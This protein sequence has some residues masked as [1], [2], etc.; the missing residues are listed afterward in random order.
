[1]G[2]HPVSDQ[3]GQP[4][5][6]LLGALGELAEQAGRD[7]VDVAVALDHWSPGDAETARQLGPQG[8]GVD[9]ADGALLALQEPGV[10]RQPL[11]GGVL[12]LGGHDGVGV[13]LGIG[14]AA[15]VLAEQRDGQASGVDLLDAVLPPP[16]HRPVVLEPV[17][18]S[19]HSGVVGGQHL[20]SHERVR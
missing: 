18:G 16:G 6:H 5:V 20:G 13:Q 2:V 10:E 8:R 9:P 17:D 7:A 19:H 12:H 4:G 15:G 11:A 3:V 1:M 14:A